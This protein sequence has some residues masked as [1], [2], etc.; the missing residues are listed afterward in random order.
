MM[1]MVLFDISV[2]AGG[3]GNTDQSS[4]ELSPKIISIAGETYKYLLLLGS[5]IMV[6]SLA[7]YGIMWFLAT[8][9]QKAVLKDKVA[10]YII[11]AL[12]LYG[13][14]TITIWVVSIL[15]KGLGNYLCPVK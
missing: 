1:L 9:Q 13:G 3:T 10:V 12:L 4:T 2:F 7:V 14:T 15:M 6:V 8:P 11:G 5:I